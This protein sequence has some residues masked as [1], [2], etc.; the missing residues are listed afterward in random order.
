MP[1]CLAHSDSRKVSCYEERVW[2]FEKES[3]RKEVGVG[4]NLQV[5]RLSKLLHDEERSFPILFLFV[6]VAVVRYL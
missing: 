3:R 4:K 5:G 1:F 6:E 2:R